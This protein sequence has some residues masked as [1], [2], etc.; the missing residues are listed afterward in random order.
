MKKP[1]DIIDRVTNSSLGW[2]YGSVVTKRGSKR[3]YYDF[4]YFEER[5]EIS[6]GLKDTPGNRVR[7]RGWLDRQMIKIL[8][9]T[10]Q[11]GEAFPGASPQKIAHFS[12][13][14]GTDVLRKPQHV[15]FREYTEGEWF[16]EGL[17]NQNPF[18]EGRGQSRSA[19]PHSAL[20]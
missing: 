17:G 19:L 7:A 10:F 15:T 5:V 9:G 13:L 8:D 16:E 12:A 1:N 2:G 3:L 14:E 20:F 11:F 6:S 18:H 4:M